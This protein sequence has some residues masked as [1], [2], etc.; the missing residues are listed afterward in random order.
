MTEN[1]K[2]REIATDWYFDGEVGTSSETICRAFL[3][4]PQG[5]RHDSM[6]IDCDDLARCR[7]F[8]ERLSLSGKAWALKA[9]S[10]LYADWGPL[11]REWETVCSS[12]DGECPQWRTRGSR[13]G[14]KTGIRI[15]VLR[16]EGLRIRYP[17]AVIHTSPDG[18]LSS[19]MN[20]GAPTTVVMGGK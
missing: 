6:P 11:V 16:V 19:M 13:W 17:N 15:G 9:V 18:T 3:G 2:D 1:A 7:L 12:M 4:R 20:G 14:P 10:D 8:L 5:K